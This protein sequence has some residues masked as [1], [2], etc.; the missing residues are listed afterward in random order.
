MPAAF[1]VVRAA[2]APDLRDKFDTWY[3]A[4]HLPWAIRIFKCDKAW[5]FWSTVERNVHTAVYRFTDEI[6]MDATLNGEGLTELIADFDRTWPQGVTRT[7]DKMV[8]VEER[9]R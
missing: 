2:V 5:R 6:T 9:D 3:S 1:F 4:E 8:L 7:R